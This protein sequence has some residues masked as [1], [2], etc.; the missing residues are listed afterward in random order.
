MEMDLNME[1][2]KVQLFVRK[3][4]DEVLD[5]QTILYIIGLQELG[6]NHQS[7]RKEQKIDV[8]HIGV[9]SV[10]LPLGYYQKI[11]FDDDGWP[12]FKNI[13]KL[14]NEIV[15]EQQDVFMKKAII[16]YLRL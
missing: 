5:V 4:F 15:G 10:L 7:L 11:G 6:M 1:W 9:C 3:R 2:V 13:K 12:H 8:I 16:N 14:P